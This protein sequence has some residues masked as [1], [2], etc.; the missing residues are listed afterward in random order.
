[1]FMVIRG[2]GTWLWQDK[3]TAS[4]C[5]TLHLWGHSLTHSHA[6]AILPLWVLRLSRRT[7]MSEVRD[8][9][10]PMSVTTW[11]EQEHSEASFEYA[12]LADATLR[13]CQFTRCIFRHVDLAQVLTEGCVFDGCDF[14]GAR[15]NGSVHAESA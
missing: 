13:A 14:T 8:E 12:A 11:V 9:R 7:A 2:H 6:S 1:M 5:G 15:L 4:R 3:S 10:G